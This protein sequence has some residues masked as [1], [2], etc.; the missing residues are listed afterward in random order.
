MRAGDYKSVL[1]WAFLL[2]EA[3]NNGCY[4]AFCMKKFVQGKG[5]TSGDSLPENVSLFAA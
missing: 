2:I 3:F 4:I 5:K 1:D